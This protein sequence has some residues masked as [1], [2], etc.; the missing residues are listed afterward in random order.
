[1][2]TI[3]EQIRKIIKSSLPPKD[4]SVIWLDVSNPS[5][6]LLKYYDFGEWVPMSTTDVEVAGI[7]D[8][9]KNLKKEVDTKCSGIK[10]YNV[11]EKELISESIGDV[12]TI[13]VGKIPI[14]KIDGLEEKLSS[15]SSGIEGI[16]IIKHDNV[17]MLPIDKNKNANIQLGN[18]LS[19][20]TNTLNLVWEEN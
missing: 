3:E 1:M 2:I 10:I 13:K 8:E 6:P 16:K 14:E 11:D 20:D 12:V 19:I 15:L 7:K 5:K 4:E 9:I 18:S 17:T